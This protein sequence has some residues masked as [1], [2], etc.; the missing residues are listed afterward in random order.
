MPTQHGLSCFFQL[1]PVA[2]RIDAGPAFDRPFVNDAVLH[3]FL[4]HLLLPPVEE[5]G[6]EVSCDGG[7]IVIDGGFVL[8]VTGGCGA[9]VLGG[10]S[11]DGTGSGSAGTVGVSGSGAGSS[12]SAGSFG[13]S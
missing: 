13:T 9:G 1:V 3:S 2:V 4:Q 5:D 12:S 6:P 10:S 11:G 8:L 7:V